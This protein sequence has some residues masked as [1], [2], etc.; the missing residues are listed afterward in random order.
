MAKQKFS[1]LEGEH[2]KILE[3]FIKNGNTDKLDGEMV[4][5]LE[6]LKFIQARLHRVDSPKNVIKTLMASFPGLNITTATSRFND[7]LQFFYLDKDVSNDA[8]RNVLFE[9]GMKALSVIVQSAKKV[10][11]MEAVISS[12]E[13]LSKIKGLHLPDK[14]EIPKGVLDEKVEIHTLTPE[15]VGLK[16]ADKRLL[17]KQIDQLPVREDEK[18]R[19][20]QEAGAEPREFFKPDAKN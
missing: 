13:K 5:Y 17:A 10:E 15:D 1:E 7:A 2:F 3:N 14:P 11:D 18:L 20:K 6:Q 12:I 9:I 16:S 8:W 19:I 4:E